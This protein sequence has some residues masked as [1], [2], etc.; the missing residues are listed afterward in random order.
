MSMSAMTVFSEGIRY[1][2]DHLVDSLEARNCGVDGEL[3]HWVLT[4][5]AIWNDTAKQFMREAAINVSHMSFQS[6][7]MQPQVNYYYFDV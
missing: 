6:K 2:K 3:V 4:V 5:P 7:T 1:L